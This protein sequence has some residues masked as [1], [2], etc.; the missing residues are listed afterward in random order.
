MKKKFIWSD[1][2]TK[3]SFYLDDK[4]FYALNNCYLMFGDYTLLRYLIGI[5]NSNVFKYLFENFYSGG[6]LGQKGFRYIKEFLTKVPLPKNSKYQKDIIKLVNE[7]N[8]PTISHNKF[9][10]ISK[11]INILVEKSYLLSEAEKKLIN[12]Q[13]K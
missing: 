13:V 8:K 6:E 11:E 12:G 7:I 3:P 9:K 1:I 5:L 10:Q 4:G 2:S